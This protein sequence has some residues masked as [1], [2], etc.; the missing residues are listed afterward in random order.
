MT[1]YFD[2]LQGINLVGQV[3]SPRNRETK[4]LLGQVLTLNDYNAVSTKI[5]RSWEQVKA[6][7]YPELAWYMSGERDITK[8]KPYSKMWEDIRN[9]DGTANSNYGDLVFYRKNQYGITSFD[10]AL[11][12]LME[13]KDTRKGIVLYNDRNLFYPNNRDLICNQYQQFVIREDFLYCFVTLRSSDAIYGLTYNMPW[14]SFV[15]QMMFRHLLHLYPYLKLGK[16]TAF[17]GSVHIYDNKYQLVNDML[18]DDFE[19]RFLQLYETVPLGRSFE[20]YMETIPH[21]F[22]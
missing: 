2:L 10:W 18:R 4:E 16:I 11:K 7:L 15:H 6:Y 9:S 1:R 21:V 5:A 8:I 14:W 20:E 19:Y 3:V 17:L 12:C 13:D 22:Y